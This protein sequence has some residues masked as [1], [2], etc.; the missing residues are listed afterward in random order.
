VVGGVVL[1]VL[2]LATGSVVWGL[3]L[4]IFYFE[5]P[6]LGASGL[7]LTIIA[8][9]LLYHYGFGFFAGVG[10]IVGC[11]SLNQIAY[12]IGTV[13]VS[14][15]SEDLAANCVSSDAQQN[16]F[17]RRI[18]GPQPPNGGGDESRRSLFQCSNR[19]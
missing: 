8:A 18:R 14:G 10:I 13:I 6:T 3:A 7:F 17:D 12:L 16:A 9:T 1:T 4:A 15:G 11:V 2:M 19:K 5:W